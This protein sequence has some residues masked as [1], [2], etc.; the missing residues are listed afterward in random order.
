MRVQNGT[1]SKSPLPRLEAPEFD[2][3]EA[4][5]KGAWYRVLPKGFEVGIKM[6]RG[7]DL[8]FTLLLCV[9]VWGFGAYA[10][11]T[12]GPTIKPLP[13]FVT[14]FTLP[15]LISLG[16]AVSKF[17]DVRVRVEGEVLR[18]SLGVGWLRRWRRFPV[19]NVQTIRLIARGDLP[20]SD[21]R[22]VRAKLASRRASKEDAYVHSGLTLSLA[23]ET[24]RESLEFVD[25]MGILPTY[26][27]RY[28][29]MTKLRE[30]HSQQ[31]GK[32]VME[33][34]TTA[35]LAGKQG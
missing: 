35:G 29:L 18:V 20:M 28:V 9:G 27:M 3:I 24:P 26:Y 33:R 16:F 23:L 4:A 17:A 7:F 8:Y 34:S 12:Y 32:G 19:G 15:A 2:A 5:P 21:R 14:M 31:A 30:Y 22:H 1:T 6:A 25:K 10:L 13:L 11:I